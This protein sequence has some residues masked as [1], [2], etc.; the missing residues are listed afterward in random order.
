MRESIAKKDKNAH[1]F[2][3]MMYCVADV[4]AM[5]C[6]GAVGAAAQF[7]KH[8]NKLKDPDHQR[9]IDFINSTL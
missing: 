1:A 8:K 6:A 2:M 3:S 9:F 4:S 5:S 7:L